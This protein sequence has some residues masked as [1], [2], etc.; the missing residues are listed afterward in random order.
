[1]KKLVG[2]KAPF[3]VKHSMKF[4]PS[5]AFILLAENCMFV[6]I[7]RNFASKNEPLIF[8]VVECASNNSD[9]QLL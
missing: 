6:R 8:W 2:I 3:V 1:M 5:L 9:H 7:K 4:K